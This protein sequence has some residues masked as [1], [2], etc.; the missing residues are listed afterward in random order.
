MFCASN[1]GTSVCV[2][3]EE[4]IA[5]NQDLR[6]SKCFCPATLRLAATAGVKCL[7][8]ANGM[9]APVP[10]Y[11]V[12]FLPMADADAVQIAHYFEMFAMALGRHPSG[13]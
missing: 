11:M 6:H 9:R 5:Y 4:V 1:P 2:P 3:A 8:F 12:P 7:R 10:V 13:G